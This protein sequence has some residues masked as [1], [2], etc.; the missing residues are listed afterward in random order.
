MFGIDFNDTADIVFVIALIL[1]SIVG[2]HHVSEKRSVFHDMLEMFEGIIAFTIGFSK[3]LWIVFTIALIREASLERDPGEAVMLALFVCIGLLFLLITSFGGILTLIDIRHSLRKTPPTSLPKAPP[4]SQ[5]GTHY[6]TQEN[7]DWGLVVDKKSALTGSD[8]ALVLKL[9]EN[10]GG[11]RFGKFRNCKVSIGWGMN[12]QI[13]IPQSFGVQE[14]HA[15]VDI[16]EGHEI[17]LIAESPNSAVFVW[18]N[19]AQTPTQIHKTS[20]LQQGDSFSLVSKEGP[21]F[22]VELG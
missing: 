22:F 8:R 9:S 14:I 7:D 15:S 10:L 19:S 13:I 17:L 2:A 5:D 12:N 3:A 1:G 6:R 18:K 11:T 20:L 21:R 4:I 16:R